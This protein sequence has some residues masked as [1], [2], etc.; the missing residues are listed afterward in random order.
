MTDDALEFDAVVAKV[1][2]LADN[3]IRVTLDLPETA[4]E[5]AAVLMALKRNEH[6]LRVAVTIDKGKP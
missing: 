6:A 4:I 1:Q 3:G 2:T 5:A